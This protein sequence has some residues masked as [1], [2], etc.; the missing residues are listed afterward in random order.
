MQDCMNEKIVK[1]M[2]IRVRL[3]GGCYLEMDKCKQRLKNKRE[4]RG[5]KDCK[6]CFVTLVELLEYKQLIIYNI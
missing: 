1:H 2:T 6:Y 5:I 3:F 4:I